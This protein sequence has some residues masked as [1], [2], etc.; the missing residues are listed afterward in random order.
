ML[1]TTNTERKAIKEE[2]NALVPESPTN[3]FQKGGSNIEAIKHHA[4]KKTNKN[5][6][7]SFR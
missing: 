4:D 1:S 2:C 3:Q 7:F 5:R 6:T